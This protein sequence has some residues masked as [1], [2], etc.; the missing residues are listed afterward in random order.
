MIQN[1]VVG[2]VWR[3]VEPQLRQQG[4]E[5]VEVEFGQQGRTRILR[6]FID[7]EGGVTLSDCQ[8]ASQLVSA[9]LDGA[10]LIQGHY[11]LEMSSPGF[12]R[13]LRKPEDFARFAGER[14]KLV[15]HTPVAGRKRFT[16]VLKGYQDGLV[17]IDC[18]GTVCEVHI[19]NLKKANLDR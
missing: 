13:P 17:M 3:E 5:L 2:R 6:L 1:E 16:G 4:Y 8:A 15:A 14:A 9:L 10:D 7:R 11:M 19:E 12:D 18:E